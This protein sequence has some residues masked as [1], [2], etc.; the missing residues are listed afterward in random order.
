MCNILMFYCCTFT[1]WAL[2]HGICFIVKLPQVHMVEK[3]NKWPIEIYICLRNKQLKGLQSRQNDKPL[4]V[5]R[6]SYENYVKK[7]KTVP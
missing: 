4:Y 1:H 7:K 3:Q 6:M 2:F 5:C